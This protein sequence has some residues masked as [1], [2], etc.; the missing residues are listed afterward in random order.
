MQATPGLTPATAPASRRP[1]RTALHKI[2]RELSRNKLVYIVLLPVL[3]HFA[4]FTA[5]PLVSSFVLTF[6]N[7][8]P[9]GPSP[10]VGLQNWVNVFTNP[11]FVRS[12]INTTYFT[13][14]YVV[15][16]MFFGLLLAMLVNTR[17]RVS[18]LFRTLYFIPV[19]TSFVVMASIWAWVFSANPD[20]IGNALL[21]VI[22][23]RPQLF[24][25]GPHEA[26]PVLAGLSVAK[27]AGAVMIYYYAGLRGIPQQTY[28]AA[29]LDGA[30]WWDQL[31]SVTLPLLKPTTFYVAVIT[32]IGSI[33]VF[34]ST[35]LLTQGGPAYAT[36]TLVYQ[37][38][39]TAFSALQMGYASAMA[40]VL[41]IIV[42][43]IALLQRRFLGQAVSYV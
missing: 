30:S 17:T 1:L 29:R 14:M 37:I 31:V 40:Y 19:V 11:V 42:L 43:G 5:Y 33:Q 7:W 28:E 35:F 15:P 2:R 3:A 10:Y 4:I 13:L 34:D 12:L 22:G 6:Y 21:K 27:V 36:T 24:L 41:F 38:Y 26:L 25:S 39:E 9:L 23:I 16:T 8:S 32:T 20:S 18:G